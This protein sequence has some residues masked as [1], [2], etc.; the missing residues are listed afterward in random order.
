VTGAQPPSRDGGADGWDDFARALGE[1]LKRLP[2]EAILIVIQRG[3]PL[4][5][6]QFFQDKSELQA[7]APGGTLDDPVGPLSVRDR[8]LLS[9][10]GWREPTPEDE[11]P[12]WT[13][14]LPWPATT[15]EYEHLTV[16]AVTAL[17]DVQEIAAPTDLVYRSWELTGRRRAVRLPGVEP[18]EGYAPSDGGTT[19]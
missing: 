11:V 14:R 13:Y 2:M 17:R 6:V 10:V 18:D 16:A 5:Y 19:T 9:A 12:N 8:R 7:E 3:D 1:E 4:H 15:A